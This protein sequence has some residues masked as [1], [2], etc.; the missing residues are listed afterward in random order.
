MKRLAS[1]IAL[2]VLAASCALP[3]H[4]K[5]K[6]NTKNKYQGLDSYSRK[7]QRREAKQMLKYQRAQQK[8]QK[9]AERK[10]LKTEKKNTTYKP[11]KNF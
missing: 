10:M 11:K 4:A 7:A 9:K 5:T 3:A 1:F 6:T 8:A 2:I